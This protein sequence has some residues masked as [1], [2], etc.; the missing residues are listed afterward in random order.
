MITCKKPRARIFEEMLQGVK[1]EESREGRK[2][3]MFGGVGGCVGKWWHSI[4]NH[5]YITKRRRLEYWSWPSILTLI[6]Q[7]EI[8]SLSDLTDVTQSLSRLPA[9]YCSKARTKISF[10]TS[11]QN[12]RKSWNWAA[13]ETIKSRGRQCSKQFRTEVGCMQNQFQAEIRKNVEDHASKKATTA[14]NT[15]QTCREAAASLAGCAA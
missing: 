6:F 11:H 3:R 5:N 7:I 8:A 13:S 9:C 15:L 1:R 12:E 10:R 4:S 2:R 14:R